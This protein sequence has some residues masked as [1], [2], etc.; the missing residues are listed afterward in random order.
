[1]LSMSPWWQIW[2]GMS[3]LIGR[4]APITDLVPMISDMKFTSSFFESLNVTDVAATVD[5]GAGRGGSRGGAG[6][7]AGG[8]EQ[9]RTKRGREHEGTLALA[10]LPTW[11]DGSRV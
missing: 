10:V 7:R 9:G 4:S 6:R 2:T 1:M 11:T 5:L 8:R 3:W